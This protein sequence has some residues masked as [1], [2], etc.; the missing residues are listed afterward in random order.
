M[1]RR[2]PLATLE[3]P[4]LAAL[5]CLAAALGAPAGVRAEADVFGVAAGATA[6]RR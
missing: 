4:G 5:L 2:P 6:R 3:S 1:P